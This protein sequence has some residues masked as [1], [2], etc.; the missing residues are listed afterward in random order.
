MV[1][2]P[3]NVA[4][5]RSYAHRIAERSQVEN[6]FGQ[7]TW[8]NLLAEEGLGEVYPVAAIS[9]GI[10]LRINLGAI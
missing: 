3:V 9:E 5:I 10:N 4:S 1:S 6:T 8:L 2:H 7:N